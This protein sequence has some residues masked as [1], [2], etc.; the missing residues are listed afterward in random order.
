M[1]ILFF[2]NNEL[3]SQVHFEKC[4]GKDFANEML[5]EN[6]VLRA[7]DALSIGFVDEIVEKEDL[8][9]PRAR[10]IASERIGMPRK[11]QGEELTRYKEV[12]MKESHDLAKAFMSEKFLQA[13]VDFASSKGKTDIARMFR[14]M[15]FLRPIWGRMVSGLM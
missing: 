3:A 6:R 5:K 2:P 15:L 11:I 7:D 13:Q 14:V 8:L 4:F 1:I 9:L 12:N 10:K